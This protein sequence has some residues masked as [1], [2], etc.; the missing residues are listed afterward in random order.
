M[1]DEGGKGRG[2]EGM[3]G[4]LGSRK[5]LE[6][7]EERGGKDL[8]GLPVHHGEVRRALLR[9]LVCCNGIADGSVPLCAQRLRV[10]LKVHAGI[11]EQWAAKRTYV[12]S[13]RL[14]MTFRSTM[15]CFFLSEGI[16]RAV[17]QENSNAL[18]TITVSIEA[19]TIETE[20]SCN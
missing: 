19:S 6:G 1:V 16:I 14:Q 15:Q 2:E 9:C 13:T 5:D 12:L 18:S 11:R 4:E 3:R 10:H 20:D 7:G 8:E 17:E